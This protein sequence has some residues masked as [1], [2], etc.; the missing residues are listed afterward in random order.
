MMVLESVSFY[1][2][3]SL[4]DISMSFDGTY[5]MIEL[6]NA[7]LMITEA[8]SN[9]IRLGAWYGLRGLPTSDVSFTGCSNWPASADKL[10]VLN[11]GNVVMFVPTCLASVEPVRMFL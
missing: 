8:T 3:V 2:S 10:S 7:A 1:T 11:M 6:D 4:D 9:Q 5:I